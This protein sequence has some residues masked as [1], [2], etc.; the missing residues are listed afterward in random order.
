M[1]PRPLAQ[2]AARP[3]R[4]TTTW[5]SRRS[6]T[7]RSQDALREYDLALAADPDMPEAHRGRGLVLEYGFG[8]LAEAE[9]EYR[10]AIDQADATPEA[11][12][13]LGQ[14]LAHTGP[15]PP[16]PSPSSTRPSTSTFYMEPWV[17]RCNKGQALYRM[18][19]KEEGLTELSNCVAISPRYCAARRE[20]GLIQLGEGQTGEALS[21]SRPTPA[22]ARPSP[23]PTSSSAWPA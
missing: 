4:S 20:L 2:G 5:R 18:G 6:A 15:L 10:R 9:A 7:G 14:L 12:N 11:H 21:S 3:P 13:D 19:R 8:K 22:T 1:R 17:A 16:R 23:T